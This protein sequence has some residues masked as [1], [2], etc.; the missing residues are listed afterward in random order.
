M[1]TTVFEFPLKEKVRNYLR[2]EQLLVQLKTASGNSQSAIHMYFFEQLFTL[3]D[4]F[5]RIDVRSDVLKDL[6]GHEKNL[7]YWSRHPNIDSSALEEALNSILDL[8]KR[9]KDSRK[10]GSLLKD[11]KLLSSIRQRFAIPGGTCGFDLPNLHYWLHLPVTE[12]QPIMKG[13]LDNLSVLEEAIAT[14]LSFLRERGH[15]HTTTAVNGFYQDVAEDKNELIRIRYQSD[16][17]YYPTLSGNKYRFAL[18]FIWFEPKDNQI[19]GVDNDVT[20]D[21]AAC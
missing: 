8:R 21:L 16:Q 17:G 1:T 11:D 4:L 18:R 6:D 19:T 13:W 5:D 12:R 2:I 20:F 3:L 10:F 14:S 15:F 9:L 7:R